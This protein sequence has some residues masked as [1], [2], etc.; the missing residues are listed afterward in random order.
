MAK[1]KAP[2]F[3]FG[4]SGKLGNALVYFGWKGLNV[5][6]EYVV[7]ANPK[8]TAQVTQRGYLTGGVAKIHEAQ[9]RAANSLDELDTS[10][11]AL[12]SS[13]RATPR[14]W[15]NE[16]VKNWV[17]VKVAGKKP[18]IFSDGECV[19]P[20][21]TDALL[22]IYL[23][24]ETASDL[25]AATFFY[26]T[27]KTALINSIVGIVTAGSKV[28]LT[29]AAGISGLTAGVKYFWQLRANA[30]DPCEG[31]RSGIYH[32]TAATI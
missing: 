23:N 20:D 32:F 18:V 17:D 10:A 3:G 30:A 15:F 25:V 12:L 24:E 4:A 19:D 29:D 22:C 7:P 1:V 28:D 11:Y 31:A 6:R 13:L 2:L 27:S 16:A 26:G 14:T 5:V 21:K 9:A 8:T